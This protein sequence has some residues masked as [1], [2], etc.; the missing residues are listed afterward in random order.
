[1][2][3]HLGLCFNSQNLLTFLDPAYKGQHWTDYG[4]SI[5]AL[6]YRAGLGRARN[7]WIWWSQ[8]QE[9][10]SYD[11]RHQSSYTRGL[12]YQLWPRLSTALPKGF[13]EFS[14]RKIPNLVLRKEGSLGHHEKAT[15][16]VGPMASSC[17]A[18]SL[19]NEQGRIPLPTPWSLGVRSRRLRTGLQLVCWVYSKG[20][21]PKQTPWL[22]R[23]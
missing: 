5:T 13:L 6:D 14:P 11:R 4:P 18:D 22:T 23:Q 15:A 2:L 7:I 8:S 20:A 9:K 12:S 16:K 3:G 21:V 19:S 10:T 1:M 17:Q